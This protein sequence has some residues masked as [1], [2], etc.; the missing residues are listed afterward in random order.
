MTD[1]HVPANVAT[2]EAQLVCPGPDGI[3]VMP[4]ASDARIFMGYGRATRFGSWESF[5]R[6]NDGHDTV[7][8]RRRRLEGRMRPCATI[9]RWT[10]FAGE[11]ERKILIVSTVADAA[12]E[13]CI[14]AV[15]DAHRIAGGNALACGGGRSLRAG[16]RL[17]RRHG[18]RV[19]RCRPRHALAAAF[20]GKLKLQSGKGAP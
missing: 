12:P 19:R 8:W 13:S 5:A 1:E 3:R 4:S 16:F 10:I 6:F 2:M 14:V 17:R 20:A 11:R 15:I 9:H 7:E 18:P